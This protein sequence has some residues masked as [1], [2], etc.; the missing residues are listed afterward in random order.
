MS[1]P[2]PEVIAGEPCAVNAAR[3]VR[4]GADGKGP[5]PRAP[6]RRPTSPEHPT[7]PRPWPSSSRPVLA[8]RLSAPD[9]RPQTQLN[10]AGVVASEV[11]VGEPNQAHHRRVHRADKDRPETDA[12][13]PRAPG[14][15]A[16]PAPISSSDRSC[17]TQPYR[18]STCRDAVRTLH[19]CA[20]LP[21]FGEFQ[22][23]PYIY[24]FGDDVRILDAAR[25]QERADH[26]DSR[27]LGSL[28]PEKVLHGARWQASALRKSAY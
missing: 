12:V 4:E 13:A 15:V 3:T 26:F 24:P 1:R 10:P 28:A 20:A 19:A 5:E 17:N 6:R 14:W 16:S 18:S 7:S 11:V 22:S 23:P 8:D 25:L 9:V 27:Q 21:G 2:P